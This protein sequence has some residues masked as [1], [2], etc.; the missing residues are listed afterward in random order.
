MLLFF[1]QLGHRIIVI[2]LRH[3]CVTSISPLSLYRGQEFHCHQF[4]VNCSS[5][6][7]LCMLLS[8]SVIIIYWY[9]PLLT[10]EMALCF[11]FP[12]LRSTSLATDSF[13]PSHLIPHILPSVRPRFKLLHKC[14]WG[15]GW[16]LSFCILH[17]PTTTQHQ[18]Y[19]IVNNVRDKHLLFYP[20]VLA[21]CLADW[22]FMLLAKIIISVINPYA[23]TYLSWSM[24]RCH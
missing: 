13:P 12:L 14:E 18:H 22:L 23:T 19:V 11:P 6:L 17:T 20:Y 15:A 8:L 2:N 7:C 4:I 24:R 16:S 1:A 3:P 10:Y 5:V 21:Y 9:H